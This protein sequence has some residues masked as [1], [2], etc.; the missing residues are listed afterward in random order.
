M[1]E[2]TE[3]DEDVLPVATL[4]AARDNLTVHQYYRNIT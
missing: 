3:T 2:E 1:R 4:V